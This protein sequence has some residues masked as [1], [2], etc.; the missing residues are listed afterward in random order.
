VPCAPRAYILNPFADKF[1]PNSR[2][3]IALS[4]PIVPVRGG[5]SVMVSNSN[6]FSSHFY[7]PHLPEAFLPFTFPSFWIVNLNIIPFKI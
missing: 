7:I 2:D 3:A 6:T 4:C 5:S 1:K